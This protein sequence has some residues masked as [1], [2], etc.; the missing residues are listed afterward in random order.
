MIGLLSNNRIE[1]QAVETL[2]KIRDEQQLKG[3]TGVSSEKYKI[4][5]E[6]LASAYGVEKGKRVSEVIEKGD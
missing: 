2:K 6:V 3:L 4:L 5:A 1:R